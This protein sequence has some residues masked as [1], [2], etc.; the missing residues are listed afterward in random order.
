MWSRLH[1]ATY[2]EA[3]AKTAANVPEVFEWAIRAVLKNVRN[4]FT[5]FPILKALKHG[6]FFFIN[7]CAIKIC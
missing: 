4:A 1:D 3:S 6:Y 7:Q 5:P 2:F